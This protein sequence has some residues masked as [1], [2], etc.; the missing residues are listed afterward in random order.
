MGA[1][2]VFLWGSSGDAHVSGY[3]DTITSFLKD[4]VGHDSQLQSLW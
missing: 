1:D 3:S 2:G 4:T